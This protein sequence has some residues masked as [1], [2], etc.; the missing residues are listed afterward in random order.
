MCVTFRMGIL[1]QPHYGSQSQLCILSIKITNIEPLHDIVF[2]VATV[3]QQL[4][5]ISNPYLHVR[6]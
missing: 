2:I 5:L 1:L 4:T 6:M 3:R